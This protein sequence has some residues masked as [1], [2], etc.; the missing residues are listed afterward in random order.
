MALSAEPGSLKA[1][2][3]IER[4]EKAQ[5]ES[6]KTL[7]LGKALNNWRQKGS[8]LDFFEDTL[9]QN[10]RQPEA[11]LTLSKLYEKQNSYEKAAR[12]YQFYLS[13]RPDLPEKERQHYVKKIAKLQEMAQREEAK[14][15][16]SHTVSQ[17]AIRQ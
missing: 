2:R 1:Q 15:N 14:R 4:I 13:L 6:Q 8:A 3:G 16:S 5:A 11:R 10:P 9:S 12:S 7:R 17:S